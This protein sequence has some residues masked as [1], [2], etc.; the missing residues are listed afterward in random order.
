M[1]LNC[2]TGRKQQPYLILDEATHPESDCSRAM[3]NHQPEER[4]GVEN[5]QL[6]GP[7]C[8]N[9]PS[10]FRSYKSTHEERRTK[11]NREIRNHTGV[12]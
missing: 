7:R 3:Q 9:A 4:M 11:G 10:M 8:W 12:I 1:V 5:V 2:N 6:S